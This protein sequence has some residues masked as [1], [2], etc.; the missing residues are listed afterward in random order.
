MFSG[1]PWRREREYWCRVRP[2]EPRDEEVF[3]WTIFVKTFRAYIFKCSNPTIL[4]QFVRKLSS[5]LPDCTLVDIG[6]VT[7][8]QRM[9]KSKEEIEVEISWFLPRAK[10]PLQTHP[11]LYTH[12]TLQPKSTFICHWKPM[13]IAGDQAWCRNCWHWWLGL[14]VQKLLSYDELMWPAD[15]CHQHITR[16]FLREA[17]KEGAQEWEIAGAGVAAMQVLSTGNRITLWPI[18][19]YR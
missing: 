4:L 3:L 7:A 15:W 9:F 10:L 14:Q 2:H 8:R 5:L 18:H 16:C 17:A 1:K 13:C 12:L 11:L 19:Y 6:K